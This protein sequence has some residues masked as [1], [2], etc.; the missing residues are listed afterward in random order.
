VSTG[1]R[2]AKRGAWLPSA[3][4]SAT[5]GAAPWVRP[6]A[7]CAATPVAIPRASRGRKGNSLPRLTRGTQVEVRG[8]RGRR[9]AGWAGL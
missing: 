5:K 6:G 8:K 2:D 9:S 3:A 1:G 7:R 4:A